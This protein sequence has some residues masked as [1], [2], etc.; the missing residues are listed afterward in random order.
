MCFLHRSLLLCLMIFVPIAATATQN[1][2]YQQFSAGC[3]SR[4]SRREPREAIVTTQTTQQEINRTPRIIAGAPTKDGQYPW[5][6]SLELLHP[7]MGFL[8]HW[9]GGVLIH[10]YWI[11]SAAH[12]I[13]NDLFNLPIP[14]LW[15][16]V[17]GEH[18]RY[19]ES[20]YEQRV[21]VDK[22]ILHKRY[23]NF[24]HDLALLKLSNP[25]NLA[26][27][28]NIRI[29][30]LPFVFNEQ[31]LSDINL[32]SSDEEIVAEG[33]SEDP[34]EP[35][36]SGLPDLSDNFLRSV[37]KVR[38]NRNVTLPSMRELMNTKIL[39]RLKQTEMQQRQARMLQ[40]TRRRNDKLMKVQGHYREYEGL[41]DPR[42]H[43]WKNEEELEDYKD[44][45]Y[46]DCVATGWGKSNVSS[47]LTDVLLKTRV[48]LHNSE[49]CRAAYGSFVKI[50]RGHL[51]AG[52]LNGK[53]GTCV[54]D[55]GGPL[56]CRL[57]KNGPWLLAG[58]TS[59]GS[60]CAMEGFPDVYVRISYY[61]KWIQDTI[62]NE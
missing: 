52:K 35:G 19:E 23:N 30:C 24:R 27:N 45:P 25:A 3:G 4:S 9:C 13:H 50:H 60:G 37:Q 11:L 1:F 21:P 38:R 54:G 57:S 49:R 20:G 39:S 36:I 18:N 61:M 5:Q 16:V 8:G 2:K 56:Q 15:T 12:C 6:A 40:S 58:I 10:R 32:P 51:C 48:P 62:A 46:S 34:L 43:Y 7:S 31:S 44:L 55:S 26:R 42:K 41:H 14:L 47:D 29:I 28:P 22:I 17:L 53:G 33:E 59:F